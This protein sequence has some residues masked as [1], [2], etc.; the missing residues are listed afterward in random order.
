MQTVI[1]PKLDLDIDSRIIVEWLKK[2]GETV[3]KGEPIVK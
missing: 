1:M 3:E 2:E